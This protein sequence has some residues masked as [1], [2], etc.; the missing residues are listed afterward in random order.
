MTWWCWM[1]SSAAADANAAS[2][3]LEDVIPVGTQTVPFGKSVQ[4]SLP[5]LP[6]KPG[7]V[8]VLRC[9]AVAVTSRPAGCNYNAVLKLNDA[10]VTRRTVGGEER[11]IGRPA[12]FQ[13]A[14]GD[15]RIFQVFSGSKLMLVYAPDAK[16]GDAMT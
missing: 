4:I 8:I 16:T 7:K 14:G 3:P 15:K 13:F 11:L 9:S 2:L 6:Q 1:S 10:P 12:M 5:P